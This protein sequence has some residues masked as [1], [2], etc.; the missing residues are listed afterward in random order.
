MENIKKKYIKKINYFFLYKNFTN[1]F[2]TNTLK[3]SVNFSQ[4]LNIFLKIVF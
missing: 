1:F 2:Q 4:H 3:A